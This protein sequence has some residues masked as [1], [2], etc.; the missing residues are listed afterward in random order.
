MDARE[1][2]LVELGQALRQQA[3]QFVTP[4]PLTQQRVNQRPE[5]RLAADLPGVFGWSRPF[6]PAT[7]PPGLFELMRQADILQPHGTCWRS[8]LRLSSLAGE[9][10]WHSAFPTEAADAVFFGPDT[11]RF[12]R[13]IAACPVAAPTRIADIGCGS[14]AAAILAARRWPAAEVWAL[15]INPAALRLTEVN[16]ALAGVRLQ[17]RHSD[18][19]RA[20]SEPFDLLLANPP[21]LVDPAVR[22]YRHGGGALGAGLSLAIVEQAL[23]KLAPGGTLLLYSGAAMQAGRDPLLAALAERLTPGG[24]PWRYEELD[25]DVFGEELLA[26]AYLDCERIAAVQLTLT[27]PR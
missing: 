15:D 3:Y 22:T 9:L 21:Y 8:R 1:R 23:E 7:L 27:R 14:G 13:A 24:W 17:T 18:L 10:F 5:N 19:L 4:T 11:Y 26:G 12:A 20:L 2:A 6:S 16:A 25:P